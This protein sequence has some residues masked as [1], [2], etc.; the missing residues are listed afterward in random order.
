LQRRADHRINELTKVLHQ[1]VHREYETKKLDKKYI[2]RRVKAD[3]DLFDKHYKDLKQHIHQFLENK[4]DESWNRI[5]RY[6]DN[7]F[8]SRVDGFITVTTDNPRLKRQV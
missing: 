7:F 8:L 6:V 5:K 2:I 3:F 1:I 4:T